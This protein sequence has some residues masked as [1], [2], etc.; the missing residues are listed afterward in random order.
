MRAC[1]H[2][3]EE[4]EKLAP[5]RLPAGVRMLC[6]DCREDLAVEREAEYRHRQGLVGA[7]SE[8]CGAE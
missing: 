5:V 7:V 8:E 4:V 2:C 6:E 3:R 1:D